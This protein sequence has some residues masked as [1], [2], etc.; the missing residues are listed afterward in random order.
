VRCGA[1]AKL[2]WLTRIDYYYYYYCR[3]CLGCELC[4]CSARRF[5]S[6]WVIVAVCMYIM[7][8]L[9]CTAT[10]MN[11]ELVYERRM[12]HRV[13]GPAEGLGVGCMY[14]CY[15]LAPSRSAH[16]CV[17]DAVYSCMFVSRNN[18]RQLRSA[19]TERWCSNLLHS[20]SRGCA[21][22]PYILDGTLQAKYATLLVLYMGYVSDHSMQ[23]WR[24]VRARRAIPLTGWRSMSMVCCAVLG[25]TGT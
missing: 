18:H 4:A 13:T 21:S 5:V 1:D 10:N 15:V 12:P 6:G 9:L 7:L 22:E 8:M 20:G 3:L 2:V 19:V 24:A 16:M 14:R 11:C 25:T 17:Q 23:A